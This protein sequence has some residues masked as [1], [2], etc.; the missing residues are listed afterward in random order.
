MQGIDPIAYLQQVAARLDD[1]EDRDEINTL[2]DEVE[3]LMEV[4]DPEL[5]DDAYDL[6]G[7]LRA[8][9]DLTP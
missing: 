1:L 6:V 9:L 8:K 7:R 4:I 5:Q 3:Y 2:L